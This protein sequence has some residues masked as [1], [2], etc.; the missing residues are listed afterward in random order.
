MAGSPAPGPLAPATSAAVGVALFLFIP[1]VLVLFVVHPEPI[2]ASLAAGVVLMVGHRMI[3][4]PY[5][6]AVRPSTC[7][8]CHR[9]FDGAH[10]VEHALDLDAGGARHAILACPDH[11]DP[12]RR[13]FQFLER[14]RWPLRIGIGAPLLLLLAALGAAAAG[15]REG[16]ETATQIFR[17]A[18]GVTV[19]AAALGPLF[20][21]PQRAAAAAFPVHNFYLLG[22]R[23]ILWIFRLVGAWWIFT[24]LRFFLA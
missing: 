9:T 12:V 20:G 13:F 7:A 23:A 14:Y 21:S 1:A 11:A 22:I 15:R 16:L 19:H 10:G 6:R 4:M 5:F 2:A 18:V 3:A 17:L 24:A 8:W